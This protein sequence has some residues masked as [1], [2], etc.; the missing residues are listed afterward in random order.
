MAQKEAL[1]AT[2]RVLP[3]YDEVV[4]D[5]ARRKDPDVVLEGYTKIWHYDRETNVI[6]VSDEIQGEDGTVEFDG[7]SDGGKVFYDGLGLTLT[8]GPLARV[9]F[10]AEFTWTQQATGTVD[11]TN[12]LTSHWPGAVN[13]VI[14]SYS[15]SAG[16]WPKNGASIGDGWKVAE[17][18][19]YDYYDPQVSS[20]TEGGTSIVEFSDGSGARTTF[21]ETRTVVTNAPYLLSIGAGEV[22]SDES[23]ATM[24][25]DGD[26][27]RYATSTSRNYSGSEPMLV[28]QSIKPTLVAGYD[29]KRQFTERVSFT[30]FADVQS[31]PDRSRGWRGAA[32]R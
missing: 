4:I 16:D 9:D 23:S 11:L 22:T 7:T 19:A 2:L 8:S 24:A 27:N 28:G 5:E 31:D 1:A 32:D 29:A 14:T 15:L 17:A 3:Y 12:Y 13:G 26:G 25:T 18:T 30:L 21:T 10:D 20:R 6:T